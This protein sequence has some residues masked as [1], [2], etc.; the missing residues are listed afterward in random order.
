MMERLL[1]G[2]GVVDA[3]KLFVTLFFD[4]MI[5]SCFLFERDSTVFRLVVL[6]TFFS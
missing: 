2:L 4:S 6:F 1:R 3:G 5:L